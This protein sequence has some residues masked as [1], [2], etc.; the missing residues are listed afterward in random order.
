MSNN[1]SSFADRLGRG[2]QLKEACATFNPSF[3]PADASLAV[4]TFHGLLDQIAGRNATVSTLGSAYSIAA[5]DRVEL[6]RNIQLRA[7]EAM[8][9]LDSNSA[10]KTMAPKIRMTA[11]KL[12]GYKPRAPKALP[13]TAEA[14][15][16]PARNS[17]DLSY[18]DLA[19]HLTKF[20]AALSSV[21]GY[22]PP[23]TTITTGAFSAM[24]SQ[25]R[26]MNT[27]LC[28]QSPQV[29]LAI[30]QRSELYF[31]ENGLQLR[32]KAIKK[33]VRAQYGS[34]S[35]QYDTVSGISF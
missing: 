27:T 30:A 26:S 18:E 31:G 25:L 29:S 11:D 15:A 20:L 16:K 33:A 17:G 14:A 12:R 8:A 28:A 7:T 5:A 13:A 32:M 1:E 21:A 35:A 9:Y 10:W 4:P 3:A 6:V 34:R 19:G 2:R 23:S 22:A 24:L